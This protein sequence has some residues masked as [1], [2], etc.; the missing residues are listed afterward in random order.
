MR[1]FGNASR[2]L[3]ARRESNLN[4]EDDRGGLAGRQA[5]YVTPLA[6]FDGMYVSPHR[7]SQLSKVTQRSASDP[8]VW[9]CPVCTTA[10]PHPHRPGRARVYCTNSCKQRAYRWRRRHRNEL[11][12]PRPPERAWTRERVHAL[13]AENDLVTPLRRTTLRPAST[14]RVTACGTFARAAF[15][16][17]DRF[18]HTKFFASAAPDDPQTVAP[19]T[20]RTCVALL[21]V[22]I[23]PMS[24]ILERLGVPTMRRAA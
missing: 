16:T 22:P 14:R 21:D 10:V 3:P 1:R 5:N 9:A 4:R 19:G 18:A 2:R 23:E 6:Y 7:S 8:T 11:V 17:P 13:R 12:P 20:C 24:V 15:D